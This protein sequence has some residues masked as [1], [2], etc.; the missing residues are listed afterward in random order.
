MWIEVNSTTSKQSLIHFFTPCVQVKVFDL[1]VGCRRL[2]VLPNGGNGYSYSMLNILATTF[3]VLRLIDWLYYW[4]VRS[5]ASSAVTKRL[6][7]LAREIRAC[8][9]TGW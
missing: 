4:D 8:I 3:I 5:R 6:C 7:G 9:T 2:Q 1:P